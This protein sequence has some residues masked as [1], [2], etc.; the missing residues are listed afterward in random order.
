M[1]TVL[2][3]EASG[4]EELLCDVGNTVLE[5]KATAEC[6]AGLT[7]NFRDGCSTHYSRDGTR[8]VFVMNEDGRTVAR[9]AL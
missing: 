5:P 2:I 4:R 1:F 8:D 9:Y 6:A 3:K 7:V